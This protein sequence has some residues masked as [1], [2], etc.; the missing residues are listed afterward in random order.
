[1]IILAFVLLLFGVCYLVA[2]DQ[3]FM[4]EFFTIATGL[5]A[6]L[7]GWV[8]YLIVIGSTL[9]AVFLIISGH[10]NF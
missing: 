8:I 3:D 9:Y 7:I 2:R 4:I 1:M 10:H 5:M 6:A